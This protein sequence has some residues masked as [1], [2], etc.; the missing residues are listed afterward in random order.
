MLRADGPTAGPGRACEPVRR[1]G[2]LGR[3]VA[4]GVGRVRGVGLARRARRARPERRRSAASVPPTASAVVA[5]VLGRAGVGC[6]VGGVDAERCAG[7]RPA[8]AELASVPPSD[9]DRVA[10][11]S[12]PPTHELAGRHVADAGGDPCS[13]ITIAA[14][15]AVHARRRSSSTPRTTARRCRRTE[16]SCVDAVRMPQVGRADGARR[17]MRLRRCTRRTTR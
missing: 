17:S 14:T 13:P 6:L 1:A 9:V 12:T 16:P 8:C 15:E 5:V 2:A 4:A 7:P 3:G 10:R 11:P